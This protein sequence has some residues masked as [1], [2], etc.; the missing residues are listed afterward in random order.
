MK[1]DLMKSTRGEDEGVV[2]EGEEYEYDYD[3]SEDESEE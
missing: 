1:Q 2:V 3:Y